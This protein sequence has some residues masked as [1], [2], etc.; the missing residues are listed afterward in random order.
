VN[1]VGENDSN[2]ATATSVAVHDLVCTL[3]YVKNAF[4][5]SNINI[6]T[7]LEPRFV[8]C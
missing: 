5:N 4:N 6:N 7:W 8:S 2:L 3:W 1:V